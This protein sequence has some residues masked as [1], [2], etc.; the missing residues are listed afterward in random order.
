MFK[1][2]IEGKMGCCV[3]RMCNI[4]VKNYQHLFGIGAWCGNEGAPQSHRVRGTFETP[5]FARALRGDVL[6]CEPRPES[7]SRR[8]LWQG[9]QNSPES[10]IDQSSRKF[11]LPK[12]CNVGARSSH[13][14]AARTEVLCPFAHSF[15][16][17]LA[18]SFV[19]SFVHLFVRSLTPALASLCA[20]E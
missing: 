11:A 3:R 9:Y 5:P 10:W 18:R 16:R 6:L 17:S 2:L 4:E 7:A 8:R 12:A 13:H 14:S 15:S 1:Y 20:S 19:R